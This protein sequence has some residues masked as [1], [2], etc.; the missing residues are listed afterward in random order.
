MNPQ[1]PNRAVLVTGSSGRIGSAIVRRLAGGRVV[2]GLD[3]VPGPETSD[4][5]DLRDVE[6][7]RRAVAGCSAV[8]HTASLHVPH[9]G[10]CSDE[11]FH[12][13]NAEGTRRL[14][15]AA[16]EAGIGRFV[17]T[18]T[19]SVYGD[20]MDDPG[21]AVWVDEHLKPVPRDIYDA[22]KLAAEA[23]C[24]AWANEKP[25]RTCFALR[26]S[27]CFPEP[28][29]D[30]LLYRLYRGVD[31]RDVA[32][33]HALALDADAQGF[34]HLNVSARTPFLPEDVR[35]LKS[36]AAAV[37]RRRCPRVAEHFAAKAWTLPRSID[38]VYCIERATRILGFAPQHD[39]RSL[40]G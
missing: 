17:Y 24:A 10:V 9:V 34:V 6:I 36:D 30:M 14:L 18:S 27:R 16:S 19:T 26:M 35:E 8:V 33:A 1:H 40:L 22:T 12:S 39:Y 38:R 11:E 21:S 28:E 29:R 32:E 37:I 4:V 3:R 20:A 31:V 13:I 15:D 23:L 7:L 25:R 5:G 2:R